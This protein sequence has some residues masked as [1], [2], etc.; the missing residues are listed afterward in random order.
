MK[1]PRDLWKGVVTLR[2]PAYTSPIWQKINNGWI[3]YNLKEA[4]QMRAWLERAIK[5]IEYKKEKP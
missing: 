2:D 4:K 5:H 1:K 3:T